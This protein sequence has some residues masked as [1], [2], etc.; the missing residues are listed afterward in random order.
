[1]AEKKSLPMGNVADILARQDAAEKVVD[2]P[3]WGCSVKVR[4][5]SKGRELLIRKQAVSGN[6]IDE[7]R[8]ESLYFVYG[9]VEPEF[10]PEHIGQLLDKSSGPFNKVLQEVLK[11]SGLTDEDVEAAKADM[12]S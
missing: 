11:I 7:Q 8:L 6:N 1:M 9:V 12:K 10:T 5:I 2:V 3:E 4:A